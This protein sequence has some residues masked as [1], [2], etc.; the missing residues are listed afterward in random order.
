M[1]TVESVFAEANCSDHPLKID[2]KVLEG[3]RTIVGLGACCC[4]TYNP[5]YNT[6]G[7]Y[8]DSGSFAVGE[9]KDGRIIVVRE[10][11]D[12][13]G[14]GCQCSGSADIFDNIDLAMRLGL[15]ENE[16]EELAKA[17]APVSE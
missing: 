13:S 16:R 5:E 3:V 4:S 12:S 14:H 6:C 17:K 15:T 10:D 9:L 2:E 1:V 7:S 11:S 8:C